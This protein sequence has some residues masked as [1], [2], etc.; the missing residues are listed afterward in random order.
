MEGQRE[1]PRGEHLRW[2]L[3]LQL[4]Y[5]NAGTGISAAQGGVDAIVRAGPPVRLRVRNQT[6][7]RLAPLRVSRWSLPEP[8]RT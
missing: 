5:W 3:G 8:F 4:K 7:A 1:L 6:P 2:P